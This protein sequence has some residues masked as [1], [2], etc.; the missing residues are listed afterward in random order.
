LIHLLTSDGF[1]SS[2]L[3]DS[4]VG[5]FVPRPIHPGLS[6]GKSYFFDVYEFS[7]HDGIIDFLA[8]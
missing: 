7:L 2:G 6:Q 3:V 1:D 5:C 4:A 8:F